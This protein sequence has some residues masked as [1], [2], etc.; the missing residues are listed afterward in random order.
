[1]KRRFENRHFID[2]MF[3]KNRFFNKYHRQ[4]NVEINDNMFELFAIEIND[5]MFEL[6]ATETIVIVRTNKKNHCRD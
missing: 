5:N 1:M 2:K 6:F 3:S 4:N